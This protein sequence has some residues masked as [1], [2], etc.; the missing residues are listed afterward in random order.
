MTIQLSEMSLPELKALGFDVINDLGKL[1]NDM[2]LIDKEIKKR[3][4][5]PATEAA[6][7]T[8]DGKKA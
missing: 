7:P 2:N 5:A 3:M 1:Q 6:T 8:K 4:L